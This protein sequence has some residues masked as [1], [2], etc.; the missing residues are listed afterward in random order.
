MS[1]SEEDFH[2]NRTV[3]RKS[4]LETVMNE[5]LDP[6]SILHPSTSDSTPNNYGERQHRLTDSAVINLWLSDSAVPTTPRFSPVIGAELELSNTVST[7][8]SGENLS[9]RIFKDSNA[10]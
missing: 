7:P 6:L 9:L 4:W 8:R 2:P 5:P 1:R 10:H 3:G